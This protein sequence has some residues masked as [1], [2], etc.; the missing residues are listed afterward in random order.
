MSHWRECSTVSLRR[1]ASFW[2]M[3]SMPNDAMRVK[4]QE[5]P[6]AT[7]RLVTSPRLQKSFA[8]AWFSATVGAPPV[9]ALLIRGSRHELAG[10]DRRADLAGESA[11]HA[12]RGMVDPDRPNAGDRERLEHLDDHVPARRDRDHVHLAF[13]VLV[14]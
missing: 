5:V 6:R 11:D 13:P 12:E 2:A 4:R 1:S 10:A 14:G 7:A 8:G 9:G 3:P